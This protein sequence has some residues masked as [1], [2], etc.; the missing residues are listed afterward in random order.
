MDQPK[1]YLSITE[2]CERLSYAPKSVYNMISQGIFT[3][4][5]HYFKP[6]P[7]KLLFFWPAVERWIRE[8]HHGRE[9]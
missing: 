6:T 5:V 2:L 8:G 7:R 3:E 9:A 4:G 1:D